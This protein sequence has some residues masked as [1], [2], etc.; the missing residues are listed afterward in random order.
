V[1]IS[2]YG[3]Q[4][5]TRM[6]VMKTKFVASVIFVFLSALLSTRSPTHPPSLIVI[7]S[8][9]RHVYYYISCIMMF[10]AYIDPSPIRSHWID[11]PPRLLYIYMYTALRVPSV[12]SS[13]PS[14]LIS[15]HSVYQCTWSNYISP[16]PIPS[17]L[18]TICVIIIHI[19][20]SYTHTSPYTYNTIQFAYYHFFCRIH[21]PLTTCIHWTITH[22]II[23][24][25]H[26]TA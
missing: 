24:I 4:N 9:I 1:I 26:I 23:R 7:P 15:T 8:S 22:I 2:H 11:Q 13:S 5:R 3:L 12:P 21:V 6:M 14:S 25:Y 17:V 18:S 10:I 19:L 16:N 20:I